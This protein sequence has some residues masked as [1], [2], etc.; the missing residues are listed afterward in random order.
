M[1]CAWKGVAV[2]L[3]LAGKLAGPGDV[4]EYVLGR[5]VG[6][7]VAYAALLACGAQILATDPPGPLWATAPAVVARRLPVPLRRRRQRAPGTPVRDRSHR[8]RA[9]S[10]SGDGVASRQTRAARSVRHGTDAL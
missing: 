6:V 7:V 5:A 1:R 8:R 2:V 9:C 10:L 3:L 4:A